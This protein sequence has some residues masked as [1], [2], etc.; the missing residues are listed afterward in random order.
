MTSVTFLNNEFIPLSEAKISPL[1]RGL[2]FGDSVYEVIPA[3]DGKPFCL[4]AHLDRLN[5]GLQAISMSPPFTHER[6]ETILDE[7]LQKNGRGDQSIYLQITRG[8]DI[9]RDLEIPT[10]ITPTVFAIS[11]PKKR[12]SK[13]EQ[14]LGMK[15]AIVTDIRWKYCH[16]KTTARLAYLLMYNKVKAAGFDEAIIMNT[17][18]ALEGTGSNLFIVRHNVIITPPKSSLLLSGITREQILMLAEKNK[19]PYRENKISERD[20]LKA[21]EVWISSS[22]RG[23]MPILKINDN[24]IGDGKPGPVWDRMWDLYAEEISKL[25]LSISD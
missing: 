2:L 25:S 14:A 19:I 22:I 7:L 13:N 15:V 5:Q 12:L 10:G 8:A 21:D 1:D 16:I 6:W 3:F 11:F 18:Y 24:L 17:G 4:A 20:L 9:I 23:I